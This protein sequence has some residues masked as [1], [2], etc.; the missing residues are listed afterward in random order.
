MVF[1]RVQ[2]HYDHVENDQDGQNGFTFS[3]GDNAMSGVE[4]HGGRDK[5]RGGPFDRRMGDRRRCRQARHDEDEK[6]QE[7]RIPGRED[8]EGGTS[9][10][11][12]REQSQEKISVFPV[13]RVKWLR[14]CIDKPSVKDDPADGHCRDQ[15]D[16][17]EDIPARDDIAHRIRKNQRDD[18]RCGLHRR[19]LL[20]DKAEL[21]PADRFP[22]VIARVGHSRSP[23][24]YPN[25][26]NREIPARMPSQQRGDPAGSRFFYLPGCFQALD[27]A[28]RFPEATGGGGHR[29]AVRATGSFA[30]GN[31]TGPPGGSL[32]RR[33]TPI[34]GVCTSC[35][36]QSIIR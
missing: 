20:H 32:P 24:L 23:S 7:P 14:A 27:E 29:R 5:C 30:G 15:K 1:E 34:D 12:P 18:D 25:S 19:D 11:D 28:H 26:F 13:L 2:E 8:Q 35:G 31:C 17:G 33:A 16:K 21:L 36:V 9:P 4:Q 10:C 22:E 6:S 3:A